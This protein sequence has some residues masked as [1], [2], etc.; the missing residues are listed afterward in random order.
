[1]N[2]VLIHMKESALDSIKE[3]G[4]DYKLNDNEIDV[5]V[6]DIEYNPDHYYVDPD[7]QLIHEYQL[8]WD[9]VNCVELA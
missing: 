6:D 1:M 2:K 5:I 7:E 8:D 3:L 9:E 4:Y